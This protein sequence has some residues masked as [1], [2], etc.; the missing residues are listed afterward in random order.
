MS[1][2][3]ERDNSRI[4]G[5]VIHL[6]FASELIKNIDP[7]LSLI[8]LETANAMMTQYKITH[9]EINEIKELKDEIKSDVETK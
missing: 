4:V 8:L 2:V 6:Q 1:D 9:S 5:A 7:K 3:E